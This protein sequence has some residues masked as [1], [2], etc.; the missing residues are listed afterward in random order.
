MSDRPE[1]D[2]RRQGEPSSDAVATPPSGNGAPAD[3]PENAADPSPP[4][5][6]GEK[7][8]NSADA[9]A[10]GAGAAAASPNEAAAG[11]RG[12]GLALAVAVLALLL[13]F[14]AVAVGWWQLD[15]M[16]R[17]QTG[18]VTADR[19]DS[20]ASTLQQ[21]VS[22]LETQLAELEGQAGEDPTEAIAELRQSLEAAAAARGELSSRVDRVA[23]LAQADQDDWRRSEAAYLVTVAEHRLRYYRDVDAAL[24]ALR[25][26]DTLLSEFGGDAVAARRGIAQAIDALIQVSVPQASRI[27]DRL[28]DLSAAVE[29]LSVRLERREVA[30]VGGDG[31][32]AQAQGSDWR[33]RLE[34]AWSQFR[35]G[36]GELVVVSSDSPVVP[37]R[38]PEE[39]FFIKQ[40]LRLQFDTARLAALQGNQDLYDRSL[41]QVAEWLDTWV[42]GDG[43]P[44]TP[45]R[46]TVAELRERDVRVELPDI[47]PM[48]EPARAFE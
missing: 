43:S 30:R 38:T 5:S 26:A 31:E 46:E 34:N 45:M 29:E 15:T 12:A 33:A 42:E 1:D 47:G 13:V 16:L 21:S 25:T 41:A 24:D 27:A 4:A 9:S 7:T 48:L 3:L 2:K 19:L 20:R 35:D 40:N 8:R 32:P 37:L 36:L 17:A 11:R 18:F 10:T 14:A 44:V 28:T 39:R 23:E 22:E 6:S